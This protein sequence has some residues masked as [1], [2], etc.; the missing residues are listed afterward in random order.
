MRE[1]NTELS[2]EVDKIIY[3]FC[4]DKKCDPIA[5]AES[6]RVIN[7]QPRTSQSVAKI[8]D[9][10]GLSNNKDGFLPFSDDLKSKI[11]ISVDTTS[12]IQT[13]NFVNIEVYVALYNPAININQPI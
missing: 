9:F 1:R 7:P 13:N 12:S 11:K 6:N 10:I 2:F 3:K 8:G 4:A 5:P